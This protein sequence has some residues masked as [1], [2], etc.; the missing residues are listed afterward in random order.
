MAELIS[1]GLVRES[2][3]PC[4]VSVLLVPRKDGSMRMYVDSRAINKIT[5]KYRYPI[6]RLEICWMSFMAHKCSQ[7]SI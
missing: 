6:P 1:N 3:S 7:R 4:A 5:I 2:V